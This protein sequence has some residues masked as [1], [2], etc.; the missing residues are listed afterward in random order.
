VAVLAD[1]A[2]A[3]PDAVRGLAETLRAAG[4]V[5]IIWG[6]RLSHGPRGR[7]A[8]DA[9]LA[10][11]QALDIPGTDGSGLLEVPAGTN[12]RGLREVGVLPNM[13]P[14]FADAAG[15]G[16]A[17]IADALASGQAS[18]LVLLHADPLATHPNRRRWEEALDRAT[19]VVAFAEFLDG[20]IA[21]HADVILPAES[22]AEREGTVVH[23]D[24]RL[25]RLRQAV[26]H[27][28][29]VR[30][31][32]WQIEQ[33]LTRLGHGTG[34]MTAPM[35]S[36]Q[37]FKAVP[38]YAGLTLEE[39]GGRGVR[40]PE[41]EAASKLQAPELPTEQLAD[42]PEAAQ[43][44]GVLRLGARPSLWSGY[45][46]RHA[47]VLEFLKPEQ[48]VELSPA[49]AERLGVG[50]GTQVLVGVNGTRVRATATVRATMPI[51]TAYLI[52]GTDDEPAGLLLGGGPQ[53][54]EVTPG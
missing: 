35:V 18:A 34:A 6:E 15:R 1:R 16:T 5:V 38:F 14:G 39:I 33:I 7:E 10:L 41:R 12:G 53:T 17:E 40:W 54:V 24:G 9:L 4:S 45:V 43:A 31:V 28:G 27:P 32:W 51:G 52:E 11:A 26:G 50:S 49:D 8:V 23:P 19:F 46:A 48:T 25:Q 30:P 44:N 47:P 22:Y 21:E 20:G 29:D 2:G 13:G 42:P 37:I 3:D 36:E